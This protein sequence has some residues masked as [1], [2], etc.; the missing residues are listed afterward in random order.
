MML[1]VILTISYILFG[2]VYALMAVEEKNKLLW[3]CAVCW[4]GCAVLNL[5]IL[6]ARC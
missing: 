4:F 6:L 3:F 5:C 1:R 2:G